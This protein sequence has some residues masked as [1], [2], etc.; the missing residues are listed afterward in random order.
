MRVWH[1]VFAVFLTALV[2]KVGEAPAGRVA[3]VVF[4]TGLG[5]ILFGTIGLLSL[6]QT[7][8]AVGAAEHAGQRCWA[9]AWS[10]AVLLLASS[11]MSGTLIVG[12]AVLKAVLLAV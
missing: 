5:L 2:L 3:I 9:L 6:F 8:A 4:V 1:L 10:L 12:M 11:A 7:L